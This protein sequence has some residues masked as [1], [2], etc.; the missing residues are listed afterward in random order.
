MVTP[1]LV[2]PSS[3]A[4]M[5]VNI[6]GKASNATTIVSD[7]SENNIPTIKTTLDELAPLQTS[8]LAT[9]Q[10]VTSLGSNKLEV[11][12]TTPTPVLGVTSASSRSLSPPFFTFRV[13]R[14]IRPPRRDSRDATY[15]FDK[16]SL[17][18]QTFPLALPGGKTTIAVPSSSHPRWLLPFSSASLTK[19]RIEPHTTQKFDSLVIQSP[20]DLSA[21][22]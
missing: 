8:S 20:I 5:A 19:K 7:T 15:R 13:G 4:S 12:Q 10:L 11:V 16:S 3:V 22:F 6:P 21:F 14:I 1:S 17:E 18:S 9:S 2:V